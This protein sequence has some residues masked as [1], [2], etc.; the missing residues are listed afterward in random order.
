MCVHTYFT[1]RNARHI[2]TESASKEYITFLRDENHT[3]DAGQVL[4]N[5]WELTGMS[6]PV[7]MA[8]ATITLESFADGDFDGNGRVDLADFAD[9]ITECR[10]APSFQFTNPDCGVVDDSV[11]A[12]A[13]SAATT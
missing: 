11:K 9:Y 5:Q 10:T 6:P 7:L 13:L 1:V 3:D 2:Y 4:Y 12:F 8:A